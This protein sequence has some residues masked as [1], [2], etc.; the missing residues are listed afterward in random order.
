MT[1]RHVLEPAVEYWRATGIESREEGPSVVVK[2]KSKK[3]G[4]FHHRSVGLFDGDN[5][6]W[7]ACT[8]RRKDVAAVPLHRDEF[9]IFDLEPWAENEFLHKGTYLQRGEEVFVLSYSAKP[10]FQLK[11]Y[12]FPAVFNNSENGDTGIID[13]GLCPGNSGSLVYRFERTVPE[14]SESSPPLQL[15]GVFGG[16]LLENPVAGYFFYAEILASIIEGD[17]DCFDKGHSAFDE[18]MESESIRWRNLKPSSL[19]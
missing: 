11:P 18:L 4:Q 12:H 15:V 7:L 16:A 3:D 14:E 19:K 1:A 13:R 10:D 2:L 17:A 9:S 6:I 5:P 8:E